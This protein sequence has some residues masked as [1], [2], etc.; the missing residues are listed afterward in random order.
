MK[1]KFKLLALPLSLLACGMG[2]SNGAQANAYAI[3]YDH[4]V[5]GQLVVTGGVATLGESTSITGTA[6]T[7]LPMNN[8]SSLAT[9]TATTSPDALPSSQG[10]PSRPNELING[11]IPVGPTE[12]GYTLYGQLGTDYSWGDAKIIT[13]QGKPLSTS[14]IEVWNAAEGN[15]TGTGAAGS[16]ASN[17]STSALFY[18]VDLVAGG[19]IAFSFLANPFAE[20]ELDSAAKTPGSKAEAILTFNITI[21]HEDAV[22]GLT[23]TDFVWTPD[24][25]TSGATGGICTAGGGYLING[26][27]ELLDPESLN[28]TLG[29]T[30]PGIHKI[31]SAAPTLGSFSAYSKFLDAGLYSISLSQA[32]SQNVKRVPEPATLGLLG[33]GLVGLGFSARRR[34]QT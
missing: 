34:K 25:F 2:A 31:Y 23:V 3:A 22:S 5:N 10:S 20:A 28:V 27:C 9:N 17:S 12:A 14:L 30:I 13:E 1:N 19:S 15:I 32:E 7:P 29:T 4:I 11:A 8:P 24:G 26:G 16:F 33:L 18:D 6:G 21:T